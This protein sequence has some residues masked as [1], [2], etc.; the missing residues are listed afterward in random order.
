MTEEIIG[1][2][3]AMA[4]A[5]AVLS[6]MLCINK[7]YMWHFTTIISV[8]LFIVSLTMYLGVI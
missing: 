1:V 4:A 7:Q 6:I 3:L 2:V 8:I 5:F